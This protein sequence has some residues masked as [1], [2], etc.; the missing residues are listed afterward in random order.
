[1]KIIQSFWSKPGQVKKEP[2]RCGWAAKKY[3]YFSWALSCL[4]FRQFYDEVELVTDK[5]GHELLIEKLE[6]PYTSC[7]IALDILNDYPPGLFAVGKLYAYS[8]QEAPF[9]HADGDVFIWKKFDEGFL[10]A[11]L[12]SQ[13][14]EAGDAFHPSY[15][16]I[17]IKMVNHFDFCP[18]V[19]TASLGRNGSIK[20]V[21]AGV[22]GGTDVG[23]FREYGRQAF[24]FIDRNLNNLDKVDV[25]LSNTIFEQ[26][27][28]H[29]LAEEKGIAIKYLKP[30]VNHLLYDFADYTG[31]PHRTTYIHT[32]GNALKSERYLTDSLDHRLHR[33]HP[34]TYYRI[35]N[36]LR[37]HQI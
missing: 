33:D 22:I 36:L 7:K 16:E 17:F 3:H 30:K 13:F 18:D 19:L 5:A 6:L 15:F 10:R 9:L 27:L 26:F 1:M 12:V 20:G 14:E 32:P 23:F 21:N 8:I 35:I 2:N 4:Q 31:V 37:T 34:D 11:P 25:R 28:F 29:A 24:E